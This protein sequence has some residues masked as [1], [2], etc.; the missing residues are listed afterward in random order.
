MLL[1]LSRN[2]VI[3]LLFCLF[4]F[5]TTSWSNV[6]IGSWNLENFGVKKGDEA[7]DI[8]AGSVKDMDVIAIQ[9]VLTS[10][11]GAKAV[12]MLA[13]ALSRKGYNWDYIISDITTSDN[14]QERERYA[15]LW[16]TA[17]V[18]LVGRPFL[19]AKFEGEMCREPFMGTFEQHGNVF[20][21]ANF[22]AVPKKKQP[23]RE[24]RYLEFFNNT[25]PGT[26]LIFLGDFNCAQSN[27]VFDL[28][29]DQR[30]EVAF[31]GQK[32]TLKQECKL[33]ECLASEYDNIFFPSQCFSRKSSGIV[34]FYLN[35]DGN[36][37][38]A[39]KISDHVP[40]F[41]ELDFLKN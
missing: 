33:D 30:Y 16:K 1:I 23:E 41:V 28:L 26:N 2:K 11:D 38:K 4:A 3:T 13:E 27:P 36:M 32:T 7:I 35:F 19:A 39:R 5:A 17:R 29:K 25:Y 20:T 9:E 22:H 40:V 8:I 6:W 12:A 37:L 21:L 24:I 10:K 15:F 14:A 18:K 31:A 34:P